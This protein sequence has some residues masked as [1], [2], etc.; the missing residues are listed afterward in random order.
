MPKT[1]A[2]ALGTRTYLPYGR[3]CGTSQDYQNIAALTSI[4]VSFLVLTHEVWFHSHDSF[5]P[6]SIAMSFTL[7]VWV[8][9]ALTDASLHMPLCSLSTVTG[10]KQRAWVFAEIHG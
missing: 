10:A 5:C 1:P 4:H 6:S 8:C 9:Y 2:Y 7:S 3:K